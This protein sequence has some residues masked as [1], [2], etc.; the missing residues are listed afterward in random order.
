VLIILSQ[1]WLD[2]SEARSFPGTRV[3]KLRS[4]NQLG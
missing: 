2:E 3:V 4:G 1:V